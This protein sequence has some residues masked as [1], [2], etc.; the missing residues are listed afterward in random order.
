MYQ[1]MILAALTQ[2]LLGLFSYPFLH[3]RFMLFSAGKFTISYT[4]RLLFLIE[5]KNVRISLKHAESREVL[6]I[7]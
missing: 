2:F 4:L 3:D 7:P 6:E 5:T 1:Q